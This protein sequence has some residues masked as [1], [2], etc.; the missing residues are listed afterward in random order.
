MKSSRT[1]VKIVL[2]ILVVANASC[3][4]YFSSQN[5]ETS[6]KTSGVVVDIIVEEIEKP[7]DE[8]QQIIAHTTL[9]DKIRSATHFLEF[10]SLG[11]FVGLLVKM[12][13][14]KCWWFLAW[15]ITA[16]YGATDE[17]HQLFVDGRGATLTDCGIDACGAF[18]GVVFSLLIVKLWMGKN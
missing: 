4:F 18:V 13:A 9:T 1:V 10:A 5:A 14:L 7:Q 16:I 8:V 17:F 12:Y 6:N 11:L 3:I 2:W 15:L